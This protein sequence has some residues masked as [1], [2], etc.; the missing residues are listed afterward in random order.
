MEIDSS[1]TFFPCQFENGYNKILNFKKLNND[2]FNNRDLI[3]YLGVLH[4]CG[5]S[6]NKLISLVTLFYGRTVHSLKGNFKNLISNILQLYFLRLRG[7]SYFS[8][9]NPLSLHMCSQNSIK[10][11]LLG[12]CFPLF[13]WPLYGRSCEIQS[14]KINK[15]RQLF[16]NPLN[17]C[18]I[19][20]TDTLA[21]GNGRTVQSS[22]FL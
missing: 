8:D 12:E 22:Q 16:K 11:I 1:N 4:L 10:S 20:Q 2:L 14:P 13:F 21:S 9:L 17:S 3:F 6:L 15:A 5:F 7:K 19:N 18:F